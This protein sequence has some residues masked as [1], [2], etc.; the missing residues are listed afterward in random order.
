MLRLAFVRGHG[1]SPYRPG[2]ASLEAGR[3]NDRPARTLTL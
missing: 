1:H 2:Y 3:N